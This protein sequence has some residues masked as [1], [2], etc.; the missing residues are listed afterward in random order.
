MK[1]WDSSA[2]VPLFVEE[3]NTD[4]IKKIVSDDEDIVVWWATR[5]ECRSALVRAKR[6]N[7]FDAHEESNLVSALQGLESTWTEILP[8]ERVRSR[9]ERLLP[10]HYLRTGDALQLAAALIWANEETKGHSIVC[11][12]SRLREAALKEGFSVLPGNL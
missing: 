4:R 7:I 1:F 3:K 11:L 10:L 5:V 8:N 6:D 9:A 2:I 12:D